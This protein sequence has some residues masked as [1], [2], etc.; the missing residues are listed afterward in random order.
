MARVDKKTQLREAT[1]EEWRLEGRPAAT[2]P[3][4]TPL[5][6]A[7]SPPLVLNICTTLDEDGPQSFA[8]DG[9]ILIRGD[10]VGNDGSGGSW[11]SA[12][13]SSSDK[14][15]SAV[16]LHNLGLLHCRMNDLYGALEVFD[17]YLAA[18]RALS[19]RMLGRRRIMV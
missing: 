16:A 18:A 2:T 15:Q 10:D 7:E 19:D 3:Q 14:E 8:Y 13:S 9:A 12:P 4:S 11:F 1:D 6:A 5:A 17:M